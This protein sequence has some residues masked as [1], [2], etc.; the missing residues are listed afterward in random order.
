MLDFLLWLARWCGAL[1]ASVSIILLTIVMSLVVSEKFL[2][3]VHT[4]PGG[5]R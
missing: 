4:L 1:L 2:E 5:L 3:L